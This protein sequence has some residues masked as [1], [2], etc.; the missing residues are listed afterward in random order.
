MNSNK[1]A[2][3]VYNPFKYALLLHSIYFSYTVTFQEFMHLYFIYRFSD[4]DWRVIRLRFPVC[5]FHIFAFFL[6][7]SINCQSKK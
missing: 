5:H 3:N 2:S 1:Y 6:V 7:V 4:V